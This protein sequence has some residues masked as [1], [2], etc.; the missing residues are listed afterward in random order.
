M[1]KIIKN[2]NFKSLSLGGSLGTQNTSNP[3]PALYYPLSWFHGKHS[4]QTAGEPR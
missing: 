4:K 2:L 3:L 1:N